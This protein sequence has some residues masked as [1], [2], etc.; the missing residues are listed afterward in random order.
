MRFGFLSGEADHDAAL[1]FEE[2]GKDYITAFNKKHYQ[3][4]PNFAAQS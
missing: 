2:P 4:D 1:V 3:R